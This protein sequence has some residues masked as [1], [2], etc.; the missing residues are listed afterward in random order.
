MTPEAKQALI[1][2]YRQWTPD[3]G[4][5]ID[6]LANEHGVTKSALYAMLRRENIPLHTGRANTPLRLAGGQ[7]PLL[8]D[9]GRI[10]VEVILDQLQE[11]KSE[12]AR[13]KSLVDANRGRIEEL[14]RGSRSL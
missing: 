9:M 7:T 13:L 1:E 6:E 4:V 2:A 3:N 5:T 14:E 11:L 8:E 12:N 10:A